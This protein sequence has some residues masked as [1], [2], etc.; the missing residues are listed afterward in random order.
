VRGRI[1][2]LGW[3]AYSCDVYH[4]R[5]NHPGCSAVAPVS[6]HAQFNRFSLPPKQPAGFQNS[7]TGAEL[8]LCCVFV[9]VDQTAQD[10][11][12]F[13]PFVVEVGDGVVRPWWAE[14]ATAVGSSTIVVSGVGRQYGS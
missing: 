10:W 4:V 8:G 6:V 7:V 5:A 12:A 2:S 11:S 13:D 14:L 3:G 9:F 1:L